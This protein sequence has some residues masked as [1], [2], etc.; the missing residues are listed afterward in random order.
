MGDISDKASIKSHANPV[1]SADTLHGRLIRESTPDRPG[2][3]SSSRTDVKSDSPTTVTW[4]RASGEAVV[5]KHE[6]ITKL[7]IDPRE[8]VDPERQRQLDSLAGNLLTSHKGNN[9]VD[10]KGF[11]NILQAIGKDSSLTEKEKI[12]VSDTIVKDV[13]EKK[14]PWDK[15]GA[16]PFTLNNNRTWRVAHELIKMRRKTSFFRARI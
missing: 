15:E 5:E 13:N 8:G 16:N 1:D 2:T 3:P 9:G 7:P 4:H 14:V 11:G 10:F 12:N 6:N